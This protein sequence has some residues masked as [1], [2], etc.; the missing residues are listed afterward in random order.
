[1]MSCYLLQFTFYLPPKLF[2]QLLHFSILSSVLECR[3]FFFQIAPIAI[4]CPQFLI[5][6]PHRDGNTKIITIL[7]ELGQI[8]CLIIPAVFFF[9]CITKTFLCLYFCLSCPFRF[10]TQQACLNFCLSCPFGFSTYQADFSFF[11][12]HSSFFFYFFQILVAKE[13]QLAHCSCQ[14]LS[15]HPISC[16]LTY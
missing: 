2:C 8:S 7:G 15:Y 12:F 14:S 11:L 3:L 10:S 1:M 6:F 13:V 5:I 9:R 16:S 4:L